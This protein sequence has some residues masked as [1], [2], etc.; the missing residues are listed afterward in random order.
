MSLDS[1]FS[2][3]IQR[4]PL[5]TRDEEVDKFTQLDSLRSELIKQ[6]NMTAGIYNK[7]PGMLFMLQDGYEA[8]KNFIEPHQ[9]VGVRANV[10]TEVVCDLLN[11]YKEIYE[12]NIIHNTPELQ[13]E[14]Y[15]CTVAIHF[16]PTVIDKIAT[17]VLGYTGTDPLVDLHVTQNVLNDVWVN[18]SNIM[19]SMKR[20]KAH[21]V[22]ANLRL[23]LSIAHQYHRPNNHIQLS[24]LV[25]E[26]SI[27]LVTATERFDVTKGNKFSTVATWWIRQGMLRYI[28]NNARTIRLPVN[29][30]DHI[31]KA[32][33]IYES[34]IIQYRRQPTDKEMA[35]KLGI[36]PERYYELKHSMGTVCSLD[37]PA[38]E[39]EEGGELTLQDV[40]TDNTPTPEQA[41]MAEYKAK[42]IQ[43]AL[44][45]LDEFERT[46]IEIRFGL[47]EN[48]ESSLSD[49]A[50]LLGVS[51]ATVFNYESKALEKLKRILRKAE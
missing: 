6:I 34:F 41:I 11:K 36:T 27:G 31:N 44:E 39:G 40:I 3:D 50:D 13:Q 9:H 35:E 12:Q 38:A 48:D 21:I 7:I 17:D 2:R 29:V 47:G 42:L 25:Q 30:Q 37:A 1:Q 23:V 15:D 16:E 45:H 14:L 43:K 28:E 8:V 46:L 49:V 22:N 20:I 18:I 10:L 5:L 33:K 26:G 51:R 24:D 4:V 32:L 19:R